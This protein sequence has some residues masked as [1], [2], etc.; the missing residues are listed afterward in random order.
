MQRAAGR[1][2]SP[3]MSGAAAARIAASILDKDNSRIG[4]TVTANAADEL[5]ALLE[6]V[7][8]TVDSPI[9]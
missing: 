6:C 3:E 8:A 1:Q 9:T 2:L 5:A 4:R 7:I